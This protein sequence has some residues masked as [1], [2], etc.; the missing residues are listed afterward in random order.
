[1]AAI[2][3]KEIKTYFTSM[4]TYIYYAFFFL[5]AGIFFT[6]N[7][8][9]TGDTQFGYYVLRNSFV[10]VLVFAPICTMRLFAQEKRERTEQM[11]FTAPVSSLS[12]LLGKYLATVIAVFI[13][14]LLS[15]VYPVIMSS[16]GTM[17]VGFLCAGYIACV[18]VTLVLISL[19]I[20]V[21][22]L[23]SNGILAVV[24]SYAV[25]ALFLL[26][27][28]VEG[29]L[30]EGVLYNVL[31]QVSIYNKFNDMISGIVRSGDII[32][33]LMLAFSL[34]V[35][36]WFILDKRKVA[37]LVTAV[38][39]CV[40]VLMMIFINVLGMQYTKVYDFT[41]ERLLTLSDETK[42]IVTDIENPTTIY[43]LG[44]KSRA[45]ATYQELLAKY[46]DL[47]DNIEIVYQ[48]VE[49][50]SDFRNQYLS[51]LNSVNEASMLVLSGERQVYL[52]SAEY[53]SS[54]QTSTY[55][56]K[57]ILEIE[58][59]LTSAIFY[60]NSTD[61]EKIIQIEG[62][63]EGSLQG[64]FSKS[65]QMNNYTMDTIGLEEAVNS[66]EKTFDSDCKLVIIN[67]P[68]TDYSEAVID[69]LENF[70]KG[71]GSLCVVIDPLNEDL[72][73]LYSF[74][75]EY[76]M[77]IQSGVVIEQEQ[78]KYAYDTQYYLVP[79]MKETKYSEN[80]IEKGDRILTMTSKGIK[81][82]DSSKGYQ[83]ISILKTS[84]QAFSKVGNF[85]EITV[86]G[87]GDI[88][89][90][91]SI[92]MAA[93]KEGEGSIFLLS[94]N[95]F[96]NT[97]VDTDSNGANRR[98]FL[99]VVDELTGHEN[100]IMIEGKEVG[101]QKAF[102]PTK[103][104]SLVKIFSMIIVPILIICFGILVLVVRYKNLIIHLQRGG[105]DN[106]EEKDNEE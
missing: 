72:P 21:S 40:I 102:Y 49:T 22:A 95:V 100:G 57:N 79:N 36:T 71:G 33:L 24:I 15:I 47:N 103:S 96:F 78:G 38:K 104:R 58:N 86:K 74:L 35:V 68:Q 25:Y 52:D 89:G 88:S 80:L 93:E 18:L 59:Q 34:F 87:D 97:E 62:N 43:Y 26:L 13:P 61:S 67:A 17:N 94:S 3:E 63:G 45:N 73:N 14:V 42:Q 44:L 10:V 5:V 2:F 19:G 81:E 48:N 66:I 27:R 16:Y 69:S 77:D 11:L 90:P 55:S 64:G 50:D 65:L 91:F 8:L 83:T 41:F 60:V 99:E 51:D 6:I 84:A 12:I 30:P 1:M 85:D 54:I 20:F 23:V 28:V 37:F 105:K 39:I 82:I 32:Y 92:A 101:N 9:E 46:A 29:I 56:T 98:F 53:V 106:A 76:G 75:K 4:T 70:V 31:H 7:C